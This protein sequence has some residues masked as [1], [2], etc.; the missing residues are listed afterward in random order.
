MHSGKL[1][2]SSAGAAAGSKLR[3]YVHSGKLHIGR[4]T[5]LEAAVVETVATIETENAH[6]LRSLE[7][8]A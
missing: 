2:P 3:T 6:I 8:L 7:N 5:A 1:H 4:L